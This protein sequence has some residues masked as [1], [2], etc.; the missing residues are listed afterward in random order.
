LPPEQRDGAAR[1]YWQAFGGKLG[2]VMGPE[3]KARVFLN[4]VMRAD[5]CIVALDDGGQIVGL[6]GYKTQGGSFAGGTEA[7]LRAVF[8]PMGATWRGALLALLGRDTEDDRF[9]LD[10]LCVSADLRGQGIGVRLIEAIC[11]EARAQGYEAVQL[12]VTNT[13]PRARALYERCGFQLDSSSKIGA[14]RLVFGF[15]STDRMVRYL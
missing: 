14:L 13:N 4:R 10:G 15:A 8:G 1:L 2:R 7:D 11:L 12:D 3:T 6:A 9:L 5:H